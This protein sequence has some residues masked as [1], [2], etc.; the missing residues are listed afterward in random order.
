MTKLNTRSPHI[1]W[2][3]LLEWPADLTNIVIP[4]TCLGSYRESLLIGGC[5]PLIVLLAVAIGSAVSKLAS[6][7]RKKA[8]SVAP[9]DSRT[10]VL[11]GLMQHT[12]PFALVLTFLVVPS[13]S[14]RIFKTFLC[15]RFEYA[16]GETRSYMQDDLRTSCD[17]DSYGS[18]RSTAFVLIAIWPIGFRLGSNLLLPSPIL[19]VLVSDLVTVASVATGRRAHI[20][21]PSALREQQ[22]ASRRQSDKP[23][24]RDRLPLWRLQTSNLLV[25][26]ARDVS[27]AHS[28][29]L[30]RAHRAFRTG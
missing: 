9:R 28:N 19:F 22:S 5:W 1:R 14:T 8:L 21:R 29:G 3:D 18:A 10:A 30:D 15:D 17:S 16:G 2:M 20:V 11:D 6:D 24:L 7:Y 27:Q 12:L 4:I 13:V 23:E 26:A 25:G